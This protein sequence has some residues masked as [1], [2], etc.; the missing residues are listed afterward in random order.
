MKTVFRVISIAIIFGL[1]LSACGGGNAVSVTPTVGLPLPGNPATP[2][3]N[4][5]PTMGSSDLCMNAY[6]PVKANATWVYSSSGAPSGP[7]EYGETISEVRLDGFTATTAIKQVPHAQV[8]SCRPEGLTATTL[9]GNNVAAILAVRRFSDAVLTNISGVTLPATMAP[10]SVWTY[11]AD[12]TATQVEFGVASPVAGHIKLTYTAG[13]HESVSVPAGTFEA[14][15]VTIVS[16]TKYT[17]QTPN[18]PQALSLNS[19]YV[20]WYA[21]NV[22]W[23]KAN[24]S[25]KLGGA[26]YFETIELVQY[27]IQ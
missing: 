16:E 9:I 24:G 17:T 21:L 27:T 18:G 12:F 2:S 8:W 25:G 23:V 4:L 15:A 19:S 10:G 1:A 5:P 11:E 26:E 14:I 22:G 6:Y 3:E 20:Y 13:D 7:Y